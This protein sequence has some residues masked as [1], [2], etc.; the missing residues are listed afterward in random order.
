MFPPR[1]LQVF[2]LNDCLSSI[3]TLLPKGRKRII[4]FFF[5]ALGYVL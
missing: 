5:E 4:F 2:I 3:H 1:I